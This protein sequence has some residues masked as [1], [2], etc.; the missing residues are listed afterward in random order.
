MLSPLPLHWRIAGAFVHVHVHV[1]LYLC[2]CV[3]VLAF[4]ISLQLLLASHLLRL[5]FLAAG[6]INLRVHP[7]VRGCIHL[8]HWIWALCVLFQQESVFLPP[9]L[10]GA[11]LCVCVCVRVRVCVCVCVCVFGCSCWLCVH[12]RGFCLP[13]F[14]FSVFALFPRQVVL[15]VNLFTLFLCATMGRSYQFYYFVPL[16]TFWYLMLCAAMWA[17]QSL[18]ETLAVVKPVA[19]VAASFVLYY[20]T[21][22]GHSPV[23]SAVFDHSVLAPLTHLNGGLHEWWFRSGL[24]RYVRG[25]GVRGA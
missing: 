7:R 8:P 2:V 13:F 23:F 10:H 3:C 1:D 15:R 16:S 14:F 4:V 6:A 24:D 21:S 9:N 5:G 17:L 11:I 22:P 25:S 19:L 12:V 20:E 18:P